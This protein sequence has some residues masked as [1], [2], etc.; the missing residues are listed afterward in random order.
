MN[1][2][3]YYIAY[4]LFVGFLLLK[5]T[6]VLN[7]QN[8]TTAS[9]TVRDSVTGE[10]LSY[11]SV[12]FEKSTIGAMTDDYGNFSLQNDKELTR[13]VVSS[14]G[15]NEKII[16]LNAN[17]K[18]ENLDVRLRPSSIDLAEVVINPTRERY[19]RRNNPAVDLI[20]NV[21]DHKDNN[22]IESKDEHE[23]S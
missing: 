21:I 20:R 10:P 7:A 6:F 14:L 1:K 22:R 15:Y 4:A 18:N 11:V 8:L 19:S 3:N 16:L 17:R 23:V 13:L 5:S 2:R 9:G 12:F